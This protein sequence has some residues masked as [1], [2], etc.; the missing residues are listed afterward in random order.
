M[1][2]F[3]IFASILVVSTSAKASDLII[4][5]EDTR[6]NKGNIAIAIYDS[7]ISFKENQINNA[8]YTMLL[9]SAGAK[10]ITLHDV[11]AGAYAISVLHDED[12][13]GTLNL[14]KRS[15]PTEGYAYSNNVGDMSIP[16]FQK[17]SFVHSNDKDTIQE[18]KFFYI[19]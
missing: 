2:Y 19:K 10:M 1:R 8:P 13:S 5:L 6:N 18:I 16:T 14:D 17:A 9:S 7:E 3:L 12:K 11:K 4:K 15:F